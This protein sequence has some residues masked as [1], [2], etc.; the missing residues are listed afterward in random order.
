MN[1][2]MMLHALGKGFWVYGGR[3]AAR[4]A[5]VESVCMLEVRPTK[6]PHIRV[7][8]PTEDFQ[9]PDPTVVAQYLPDVLRVLTHDRELYVCC[10]GGW[11]RTGLMLAIIAKAW[12]IKD[13]VTF[14]RSHYSEKGIETSA[15]EEYVAAY[16]VPWALKARLNWWKLRAF[17]LG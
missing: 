9:T 3:T 12:G 16:K 7:H 10:M 13:P 11:G 2:I 15:Q 1:G 4:P 17:I 6:G 5:D 8:I 14:M